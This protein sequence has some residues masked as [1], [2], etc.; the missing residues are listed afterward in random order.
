MT[1][2]ELAQNVLRDMHY[3]G[4]REVILCAGA[5]NAPFVHLL[6]QAP[7][8]KTYSFF[9][10]RSAA[11]FALG[12]MQAT[13]APVAVITTS[14]TAAAELLPACIEAD[15]QRLPLL[16]ITADRP[17]RYRGSGAPQTIVQP[18]LFSH[19]TGGQWDIQG[20]YH[21]NTLSTLLERRPVHLNISFDEPL[22]E[23]AMTDWNLQTRVPRAS[24]VSDKPYALDCKSPLVIVG[25]LSPEEAA[26]V[27]PLLADWKRPVYLEGPSRLRG[28]IRTLEVCEK[29]I[30]LLNIDS[31]IRIGSVPTLRFW[32]ELESSNLPV[33][34]FSSLPFS[35]MARLSEVQPLGTLPLKPKF[36]YWNEQEKQKDRDLRRRHDIL[37]KEF[38]LSEP[39]WVE[40][41]SKQIPN[42]ARLL[43]GN[44]L[45]IREWDFAARADA[46]RDI[47][48]NRG[49]NGID[50]LISTF[51]G[52]AEEKKSNWAV[53]GDL[54]LMYDLSGPWALSQRPLPEFNL[55]VINNGGGQ[56]FNRMFRDPMFLN[57]HGMRFDGWA[58]MWNLDYRLLEQPS[59]IKP[60]RQL[61][62]ILPDPQQTEE[63]WR[64]WEIS[65]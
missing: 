43:L 56:I 18:G 33:H 60:G 5:R 14:G 57:A 39:G 58:K 20:D 13:T 4:V 37:L 25:G 53:I 1:N 51:A 30:P 38:P 47:F 19:Y 7:G 6:G 55:A 49:T 22:I 26:H 41:L 17:R 36:D 65:K 34:N 52:V 21:P 10:E 42:N 46:T 54:S 16:M 15:Y 32:R 8:F 62:E 24:S 27:G 2:L 31:V 12:R 9:E 44:S 29:T 48:A 35:G 63:F 61:I 40:W 3:H 11:F 59:D 45:P 64:A 50:G 28:S 23:G